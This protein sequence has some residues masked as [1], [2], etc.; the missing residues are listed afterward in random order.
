MTSQ[1]VVSQPPPS[2]SDSGNAATSD[3]FEPVVLPT[4]QSQDSQDAKSHDAKSEGSKTVPD[5]RIDGTVEFTGVPV[6]PPQPLYKTL[7]DVNAGGGTVEFEVGPKGPPAG[8]SSSPPKSGTV[9]E[10]AAYGTM[11]FEVGPKKP[12]APGAGGPK[13]GTVHDRAG[14]G[15]M[16][17]A[18]PAKPASPS[19]RPAPGAA[20]NA[21][22]NIA[23]T[24]D[25]DSFGPGV[26]GSGL[27]GRIADA[28]G[29]NLNQRGVGVSLKGKDNKSSR[30]DQTIVVNTRAV[31]AAGK[32]DSPAV[33][34]AD[35]EL[36]H[37]L[38]E[39]GMGVVYS[40]RQTSID[41]T[42]ALKML[43]SHASKNRDMQQKFMS[44]AVVTGDLD[45][46]NIVPMYD[47]GKNENGDLFYAM[48]RVQGTPWSKVIAQKSQPENIEILLKIADAVAFAHAR[49]VIHRDLKPENVMLG[50]FGEVLLMDWGLA[51]STPDFR[52]A[53]S[54]TQTHSMGGS[55]AYMAPEMATGPIERINTA[56]D[57]YLLGA[58]LYE[59]L[60]GKAPHAGS[61]V[62]KCLIAAARN[63]IIPT[64]KTGELIDVARKAMATEQRERYA[65][66]RELQA[67][68]R[69]CL[70]HSESI[71]LAARADQELAKAAET[72]DYR[73]FSRAVF[74][75]EEALALWSGNDHAAARRFDARLAYADCAYAKGDYDLAA[76][77]LE[78]T[79]PTHAALAE[80][81]DAA[82]Q[83]REARRVRLRR[84][85][86]AM[87]AAIFVIFA[88]GASAYYGI[89]AQRDR[90]LV[91]EEQ[92]RQDRDRAVD[93]EAA[94]K[95]DRDRAVEAET[96]AV[97]AE[98]KTA[99][100]R[101]R[102][103]VA[104]KTAIAAEAKAKLDRDRAVAAEAAAKLDRDRAVTAEK[105]ALAAETKARMDRDRAVAAEK[106]ALNAENKAKLDRDRAVAAEKNAV[107][108]ETK[109]KLDRDRAVA[110]EK[111]AVAAEAA[112]KKDR[113]RAVVAETKT[114][115]ER[116]RAV[117]AEKA[118][119]A[120]E[121]AAK[122]DRDLAKL[123]EIAA[124]K[125]AEEARLA[126]EAEEYEAYVARIGLAA[127]RIE[128][129]A[130]STA[131]EILK[132]SPPKM[133]NWEWG[134]LQYLSGRSSKSFD[135]EAPIEAVAVDTDWKRFATGGWNGKLRLWDAA[136]GG[137][138]AELP[139]G[140]SF[141]KSVAFSRDGRYLA[142]GGSDA[143]AYV[144]VWD[145]TTRTLGATF[146]GHTGTVV[147]VAFDR[148]GARLLTGSSDGTARL[149]NRETGAEL[150]KFHGH[151]SAVNAA[152]LS[153]DE[154]LVVTAGQDGSAIVWSVDESTPAVQ[155]DGKNGAPLEMRA[156]LGHK[157]PIRGAAFSPDGKTVA[158]CGDDK[159]IL[160][161]NP[162]DVR[163]YRLE[164]VFGEKPP[165]PPAMRELSGHRAAVASVAFSADGRRLASGGLDNA[166]F[167][168]DVAS[169]TALK[170][171]RGHA[172]QVRACRISDDGRT[173][174]SGSFDGTLKL[175]DVDDY[176]ETLA[177]K[178]SSLDG[179]ADAVLAADFSPDETQIITAGLDRTA[180]LWDA[181]TL[182][183]TATLAEGHEY[184][185]S[186][187][188]FTADGS[189]LVTAG[190]DGTVRVWDAAL[191]TQLQQFDDTGR[192]AAVA[193]SRDGLHVLTGH[194]THGARLWELATGKLVHSFP[195]HNSEVS[196]AAISPDGK[197]LFTGEASGRTNVWSAETKSLV[198][199]E[200][201]H[202]RKITGAAF[203]P[204]G[205]KLLTASLDDTVGVWDARAGRE[206]TDQVRKHPAGVTSLALVGS[207]RMATT[208]EDGRLRLWSLADL[209]SAAEL[210]LPAGNYAAVSASFGGEMVAAIDQ[211][212]G[213]VRIL[214]VK[215]NREI[216]AA[217]TAGSAAPARDAAWPVG[218][219]RGVAVWNAVFAPDGKTLT[220]LGGNEALRWSI[221]TS[222][223]TEN[224]EEGEPLQAY[225]PH[226]AIAGVAFS[227]DG[228]HA[229][230]AGWD[231][232]VKIWDTAS[233]RAIRKLQGGHAGGINSVV[234]SRDGKLLLTAGDDKTAVV[235]QADD[236]R[237]VRGLKGHADR[238]THASFSPDGKQ[239]VT[240]SAD[241]TAR[242]WNVA[243]GSIIRELAGNEWAVLWAEFSAD[244]NRVVTA[245]ADDLAK[246]WDA[247][248]GKLQ[249]TLA[250]HTAAVNT[251]SFSPDGKRLVTGSRD[252]GVKLWDTTDGTELLMLKGHRQ[253]VTSAKFS[254][255]GRSILTSSRDG[256]ALVWPTIE[257]R[258]PAEP[259]AK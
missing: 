204:D 70:A 168:W 167:V 88:G 188:A 50:D 76:G 164:E 163:P 177:V 194:G 227:P 184:L 237:P 5:V 223:V 40:A 85:K 79:I 150:K 25:S 116:D 244:G 206:F 101:D 3:N 63:E 125:S 91:A 137:L 197:L 48:K 42:V 110:A 11:E 86:R 148:N 113:D 115:V 60:T 27:E 49:G 130:F 117:M 75:F 109:A 186:N 100:E 201:H 18:G 26:G 121:T 58:I 131:V 140:G 205:A 254:P 53:A 169:A 219:G 44:E 235:W 241:K 162:A 8:E 233:G 210:P 144:Q 211:E 2:E 87:F 160:L 122:K 172:G 90:A 192:A 38:G 98:A 243:D 180:K 10:G 67:A 118:A 231:G 170:E 111:L 253:E 255:S 149:W 103:V 120:A 95:K 182:K 249:L 208:A 31:A 106:L 215:A 17:F 1:T 23:Q 190:V 178:P 84:A 236:G 251:A 37:L 28:W 12:E 226:G 128:E 133:R 256:R 214:D 207:D 203:T 250:G 202:S 64:E 119:V 176:Q 200:Q 174:A 47:L 152:V 99:V 52:K 138:L 123:A 4:S 73:T 157:A 41:R 246:I 146:A 108:S 54:I 134:R 43:K 21:G 183:S 156:F 102:A 221:G 229:A 248:T 234:Y 142:V 69:E 198:W 141:V 238:V 166:I 24:Y 104:E 9:V 45:H 6:E 107:A 195:K 20:T 225:R 71:A 68:I 65:S 72:S 145:L 61:N 151:D 252:A 257:W 258:E 57:V 228:K 97:A 187:G 181:R 161:W 35:Y 154:K 96:V 19:A 114:A 51:Y 127:A 89:R 212:A 105:T 55:P 135:A 185:A 218:P 239:V 139:Y 147:S 217:A 209:K 175:W 173:V 220:T 143:K 129:N 81:I 7:T 78:R 247:K 232:I 136:S 32:K 112:A 77:L 16:E 242:I 82:N 179:H 153:P 155:Q 13:P 66:V 213:L 240:A 14:F 93:A 59:I 230:T 92:A 39:G 216:T 56:S 46:P 94:A 30:T 199:S 159:R 193:V 126:K 15:T 74:G 80:K 222:P 158:T 189:R 196:F 36:L 22:G 259:A 29:T 124:K 165:A 245:G 34:P 191:G 132:D 83:E 33:A 171:L 62:S 224:T